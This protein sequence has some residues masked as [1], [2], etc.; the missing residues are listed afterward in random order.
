MTPFWL[1]PV[2]A[3][4]CTVVYVF[5]G[6]AGRGSKL[7]LSVLVVLS[8]ILQRAGGISGA[9]GLVIQVCVCIYVLVW[10]RLQR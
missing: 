10:L 4:A 5:A 2:V 6:E 9:I 3:V 1:P 7:A 8:F